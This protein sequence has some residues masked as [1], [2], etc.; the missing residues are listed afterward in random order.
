MIYSLII[1]REDELIINSIQLHVL[2]SPPFI[3]STGYDGFTYASQ[4]RSME[5]ADFDSPLT[6]FLDK[7]SKKGRT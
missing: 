7:W 3:D 2:Q 6:E 1:P 4:V 5:H